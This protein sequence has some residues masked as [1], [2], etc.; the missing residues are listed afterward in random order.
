M[1]LIKSKKISLDLDG[2]KL[3]LEK[4]S[5]IKKQFEDLE[6]MKNELNLRLYSSLLLA[7]A[8]IIVSSLT[9][10]LVLACLFEPLPKIKKHHEE[11][12][13]LENKIEL[14]QKTNYAKFY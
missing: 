6:N 3:S 4:G 7:G 14:M 5:E 8:I 13:L 12:V 9:H 1:N 2:D 11:L 10:F